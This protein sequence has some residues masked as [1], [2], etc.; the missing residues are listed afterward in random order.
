MLPLSYFNHIHK[1]VQ[2]LTKQGGQVLYNPEEVVTL[3]SQ[4]RNHQENRKKDNINNF[5]SNNY[6][7]FTNNSDA[8]NK[9]RTLLN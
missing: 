8:M 7:R 5:N 1:N 6:N 2:G 3:R 9:M 4:I